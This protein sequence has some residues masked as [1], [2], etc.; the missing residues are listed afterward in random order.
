MWMMTGTLMAW[1]PPD[2]HQD[3]SP[4]RSP[5]AKPPKSQAVLFFFELWFAATLPAASCRP[6]APPRRGRL[7]PGPRLP[8]APRATPPPPLS[9]PPPPPLV[10]TL[11]SCSVPSAAPSHPS[12]PPRHALPPR[13]R[14]RGR[15][16]CRTRVR[17]QPPPR[18]AA[19]AA[20]APR[21]LRR[22]GR[23]GARRGHG[24]GAGAGAGDSD[25]AGAGGGAD[26]GALPWERRW[27]APVH[28]PRGCLP[29]W[30][31]RPP[32]CWTRRGQVGGGR[33]RG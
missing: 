27:G 10:P 13:R 29:A 21:P 12:H 28:P 30:P 16:R 31:G 20:A 19:A 4:S 17:A 32:P 23:G 6:C 26:G 33:R 18:A 8:P 9:C 14:R 22:Q 24:R 25:C 5:L 7:R 2:H 3:R 1:D 11:T 15:G